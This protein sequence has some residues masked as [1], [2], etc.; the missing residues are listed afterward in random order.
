[1]ALLEIFY[2]G[3]NT[4]DLSDPYLIKGEYLRAAAVEAVMAEPDYYGLRIR[5]DSRVSAENQILFQLPDIA[6]DF[7]KIEHLGQRLYLRL[8]ENK[9]LNKM[10][11]PAH[12]YDANYKIFDL[13]VYPR[14]KIN[15]CGEATRDG[16][17]LVGAALAG[18][19]LLNRFARRKQ[20]VSAKEKK[21]NKEQL[22]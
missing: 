10:L 3:S 22:S 7:A 17:V 14:K 13:R 6:L 16:V 8:K 15:S 2:V 20:K 21:Q 1:M 9:K 18:V 12:S 11:P 4:S 5:S 19:S